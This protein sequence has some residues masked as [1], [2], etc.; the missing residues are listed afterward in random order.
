MT[1][2]ITKWGNSHGIRLPKFL[3]DSLQFKEKDIIEI[4]IADDSIVM[5]KKQKSNA[6]HKTI[7]ERFEDCYGVDFEAALR[8]NPY[9]FQEV[10]WGKPEGD[11]IW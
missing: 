7:E 10:D 9:D 2:A 1:A 4:K 5:K 8:D 6:A 3:L 11:E